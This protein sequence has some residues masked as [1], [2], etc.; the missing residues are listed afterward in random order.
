VRFLCLA[1]MLHKQYTKTHLFF[2]KKTLLSVLLAAACISS[3]AQVT[4]TGANLNPVAGDIFIGH[5]IGTTGVD[6][7]DAGTDVTWNFSTAVS[8]GM[9]T[10][11][12]LSCS[13]T[14]HCDSFPGSNIVSYDNVDYQ[15]GNTTASSLSF[16]GSYTDGMYLHLGSSFDLLAYPLTMSAAHADTALIVASSPMG[17]A[18]ITEYSSYVVDASGTL[19]LPSGT[20]T[21][22]LRLHRTLVTKDSINLGGFPF[23]E[24]SAT[25]TYE[26][27][28]AGFHNTLMSITYDTAGSGTP[29]V[30]EAK[31]FTRYSTTGVKDIAA[32]G[33]FNIYPNPAG[34]V[35]NIAFNLKDSRNASVVIADLMGRTVKTLTGDQLK[36]GSNQLAISVADLADGI[37]IARIN[38]AEGTTAQKFTVKK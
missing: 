14:P 6:K 38:S 22:V 18:Y 2:M 25:E 12:Y 24:S 27:Y 36:A 16:S 9:D 21:N 20:Y 31:Y 32:Q 11:S 26:W 37:Y 8:S 30:S 28:A 7:G 33:A 19:T 5:Y 4:L 23:S 34:N 13:A 10:M 3:Q 35:V 17:T 1:Q 29:Q 15:F